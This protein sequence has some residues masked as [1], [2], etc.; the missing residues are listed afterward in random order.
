MAE[1]YT[2][3]AAGVERVV[4]SCSLER[5]GGGASPREPRLRLVVEL[6]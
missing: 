3:T 2:G 5:P 4:F 6:A 1:I